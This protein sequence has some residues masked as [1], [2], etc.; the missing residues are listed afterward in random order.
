MS[1]EYFENLRWRN[2]DSWL[3]FNHE[4]ALK[5]ISGGSIL[6]LGCGDGTLLDFL[7]S[8]NIHARGLD[9]SQEAVNKW[10]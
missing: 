6:D 5:M 3:G 1:I 2:R 7:K 8:R 4:S 9:I 10:K